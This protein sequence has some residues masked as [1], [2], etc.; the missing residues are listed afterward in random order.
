MPRVSSARA[1]ACALATIAAMY[2]RPNASSSAVAA[3]SA[4]TR[5]TWCVAASAGKTAS[6]SGFVSSGSFQAITP[7]LRAGERLAGAAGE[8]VRALARAGPGTGRRRSARA[9]GRRRRRPGRPTR[10]RSSAISRT[11]SGNSV[12]LAPSATSFGRA[13]RA[14]TANAGEVDLELAR[15]E[16]HVDDVQPADPGRAVVAGW[17]C[18][19]RPA[20]GSS[21]PCRRARSARRRRPCCRSCSR[22]AGARRSCVLNSRLSSSTHSASISSMWRVPANQRLTGPMW[23]SAARWPTSADSSLLH[24]RAD[25]RLG[26]EQVDALAAAPRLVALDGR[27]HLALHRRGVGGGVEQRARRRQRL[28]VVDVGR[29]DSGHSKAPVDQGAEREPVLLA[30]ARRSFPRR[31]RPRR[32]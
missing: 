12:M 10:E 17:S 24:G 9:G 8:H 11:G 19:R 22:P 1:S 29:G 6:S 13:S 27:E 32:R 31:S 26:R 23:P 15:V 7:R 21:S 16:R 25:Q 4:A 14:A 20:A 3:A 5:L 30:P 28:G 18:A 2:S